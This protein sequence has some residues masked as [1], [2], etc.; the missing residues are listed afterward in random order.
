MFEHSDSLQNDKPGKSHSN[1]NWHE[2]LN[3]A[4]CSKMFKPDGPFFTRLGQIWELEAHV[5]ELVSLMVP[6]ASRTKNPLL[7]DYAHKICAASE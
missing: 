1:I 3:M 7:I 6:E 4:F 2:A 5:E